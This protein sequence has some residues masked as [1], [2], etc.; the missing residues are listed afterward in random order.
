MEK[1]KLISVI[2][3]I[4][5]PN[6][7]NLQPT[8][9]Y[10][11]FHSTFPYRQMAEAMTPKDIIISSFL[12][13]LVDTPEV[14][15][16]KYDEVVN[17]LFAYSLVEVDS[18]YSEVQC[19]QCDGDGYE[20][21]DYCDGTG[22][23]ECSDCSGNGR[24]EEDDTCINCDGD[25]DLDCDYCA[26]DGQVNCNECGGSGTYDDYDKREISQWFYASYDTEL[27]NEFLELD[28][29]DEM[30]PESIYPNN[31]TISL[32]RVQTPIV[33]PYNQKLE[34]DDTYFYE[35]I[36]EPKFGKRLNGRI[37]VDNLEELD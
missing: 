8:D 3:K 25:G 7:S 12:L 15:D 13:P 21:C 30:T 10:T 32:V 18:D 20:N 27:M 31:K 9:I 28:E 33:E 4:H 11:Y 36:D 5:Q 24:D 29:W 6:F 35:A 34:K 26:G 14:L 19:P 16:S 17:N 22:R 1:N 23:E 2:K 37:N